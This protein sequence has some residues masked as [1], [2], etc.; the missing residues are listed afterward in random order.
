MLSK[1]GEGLVEASN[2]L[3]SCLYDTLICHILRGVGHWDRLHGGPF[4]S[5]MS[6]EAMNETE[7]IHGTRDITACTCEQ[8]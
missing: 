5:I 8:N 3:G 2:T 4:R 1:K 6:S 7:S